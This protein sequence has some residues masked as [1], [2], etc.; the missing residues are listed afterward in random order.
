MAV[1]LDIIR[2]QQITMEGAM[3][4]IKKILLPTDFFPCA[5]QALDHALYLARKYGA[6]FHMLHAIVLHK[7]DPHN[8]AA[9][10]VNLDEIDRRLKDLA[11]AD[12]T[13]SLS[14]RD[15]SGVKVVMEQRHGVRPAN[16]ILNY[17]ASEDIDLIVMGTHGRR[18]LGHLLLGSVSE[19]V[20]RMSDCPVLTIRERAE[21]QDVD[22]VNRILVPLD[23][24]EHANNGLRHAKQLAETYGAK[25]DLVHVIEE[26]VQPAFYEMAG[27][28]P[29]EF[30]AARRKKSV[31]E[32]ER[33]FKEAGGPDVSADYFV[34]T[35]KS[36]QD[37]VEFA[38]EANIDLIVIATHGLTGVQHL[39]LGSIT[40]KVVRMAPCPV[41]TVKSFGKSLV[42]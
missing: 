15:D 27:V 28:P 25:L 33:L 41:F 19:E 30:R 29:E 11:K 6:E 9:H 38:R 4:R 21:Q 3:L 40:E 36:A 1:Q 37:I 31:E 7:D 24:S 12:M 13:A 39:L 8:P 42:E 10:I 2:S 16:V 17:A 35:G 32:M 18:G 34:I 26:R 5:N 23:F 22:D 20:V 14:E